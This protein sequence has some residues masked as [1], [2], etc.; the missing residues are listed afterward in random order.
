MGL[1]SVCLQL[2]HGQLEALYCY[3]Y[4]KAQNLLL[5]LEF[6]VGPCHFFH[7]SF[8]S[9][10]QL[11]LPEYTSGEQLQERLLLAIHEAS[12]GFGFG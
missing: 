6:S 9:F 1:L 7:F 8:S 2:T 12:E 5:I 4:L 3:G 11:D 10:N